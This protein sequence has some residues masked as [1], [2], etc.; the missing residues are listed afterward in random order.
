MKVGDNHRTNPLSLQPG[1]STVRVTFKNG[2]YRDYDKVKHPKAFIT[3]CLELDDDIA[4]AVI[5]D[6]NKINLQ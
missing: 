3:K 4:T 2:D 5:L 1:G 6:P